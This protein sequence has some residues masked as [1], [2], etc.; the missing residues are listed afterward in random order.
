M[1]QRNA[2]AGSVGQGALQHVKAT[3]GFVGNELGSVGLR[4]L[5]TGR[6]FTATATNYAQIFLF[7]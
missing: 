4:R 3:C 2:C 5:K 1:K 6:S 7:F